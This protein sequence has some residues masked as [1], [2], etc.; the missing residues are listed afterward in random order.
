M[1]HPLPSTLTLGSI[2]LF[3]GMMCMLLTIL[4]ISAS[5]EV[6]KGSPHHVFAMSSSRPILRIPPSIKVLH[7]HSISSIGRQH[8]S[9]TMINLPIKNRGASE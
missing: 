3:M 2:T 8:N 6:M 4:A 9:K 7:L 5:I 1:P